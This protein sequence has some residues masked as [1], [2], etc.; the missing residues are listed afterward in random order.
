MKL[1]IMGQRWHLQRVSK[2]AMLSPEGEERW[3][4]CNPAKCLMRVN[5]E[6][7]PDLR[8]EV[9]L[10]ELLHAVDLITATEENAL[11]ENQVQRVSAALFAALRDN[12]ESGG[13]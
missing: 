8:A 11:T 10:H 3:G 13:R 7:H 2:L 6:L 12:P 5:D 9:I 1:K 4:D